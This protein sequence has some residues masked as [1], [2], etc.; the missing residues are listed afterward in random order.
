MPPHEQELEGVQVHQIRLRCG[1]SGTRARAVSH[2][3]HVYIASSEAF[4]DYILTEGT[5]NLA[6][7]ESLD[8]TILHRINF[9]THG[10]INHSF[11][12]YRSPNIS[13]LRGAGTSLAAVSNMVVILRIPS[14][15]EG[16]TG[17]VRQSVRHGSDLQRREFVK[18]DNT[19][20][21]L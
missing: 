14:N 19:S 21:G 3:K 1:S 17:L 11:R 10:H 20:I 7:T 2:L 13:G 15:R 6:T 4:R 12:S 9:G 5:N 16:S 18:R 8:S